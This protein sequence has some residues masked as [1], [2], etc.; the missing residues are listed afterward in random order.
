D[1]E[2]AIM[3]T[4]IDYHEVFALNIKIHY[5][6]RKTKK[7]LSVFFKL[8]KICEEYRPHIIHCWDSM[9]AIYS[10]PASWDLN[11]KLVNGMVVDY[12]IKKSISNKHWFR[13]KLTFFFSSVIVGNSKSGLLAYRTSQNKSFVIYNGY[14]FNRNNH[15]AEKALIKRQLDIHTEYIIAMVA[16]FS[17]FKDYRT[18]YRA[19]NIILEKR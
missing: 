8:Y 11:I 4:E 10:I 18:Y 19:A 12:P 6:I 7:D 14:N 9:T 13:A 17:E 15:L 2:L 3:N 1:F 5:L 16:S